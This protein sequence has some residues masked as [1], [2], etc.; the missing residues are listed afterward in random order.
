NDHAAFDRFLATLGY[1]YWEETK[2]PVY[3]LFLG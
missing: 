2:N 1:P 3:G